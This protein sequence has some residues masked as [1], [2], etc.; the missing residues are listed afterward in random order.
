MTYRTELTPIL[1]KSI[2]ARV[3]DLM[4]CKTSDLVGK[5]SRLNLATHIEGMPKDLAIELIMKHE[6]GWHQMDA[7][8]GN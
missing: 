4:T 5:V 2:E 8:Y 1:Q 3:Q 7:F 6:Y